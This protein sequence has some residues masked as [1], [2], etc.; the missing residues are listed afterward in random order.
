MALAVSAPAAN[1]PVPLR[2]DRRSMCSMI[3]A[4]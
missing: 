3:A 4:P 1:L 2:N